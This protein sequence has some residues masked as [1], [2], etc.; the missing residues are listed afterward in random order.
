MGGYIPRDAL[1][2]LQAREWTGASKGCLTIY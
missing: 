1:K 2:F